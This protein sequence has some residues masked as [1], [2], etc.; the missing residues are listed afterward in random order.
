M[1]TQIARGLVEF[2][3]SGQVEPGSRMPSERA[4]AEAF[5]LVDRLCGR[6]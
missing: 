2:I 6:R 3:L 4:L 1:A 5:G